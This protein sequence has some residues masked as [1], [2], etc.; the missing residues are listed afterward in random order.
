MRNGT[1]TVEL[2]YDQLRKGQAANRYLYEHPYG[3]PTLAAYEGRKAFLFLLIL[4]VTVVQ[5]QI[6]SKRMEQYSLQ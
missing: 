6:V 1:H 4:A 5:F 2:S 3:R